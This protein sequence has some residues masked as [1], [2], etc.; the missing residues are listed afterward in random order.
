MLKSFILER[1]MKRAFY[2]I[3]VSLHICAPFA[4]A[5]SLLID[6]QQFLSKH[7]LKPCVA[8]TI[9]WKKDGIDLTTNHSKLDYQLMSRPIP[10]KRNSSLTLPFEVDLKEGGFA[11]RF[12]SHDQKKFLA[13]KYYQ[14][15]GLVKDTLKL[16][17]GTTDE[18]VY[19]IF[20]NN[21]PEPGVSHFIV[22]NYTLT[23][24]PLS[25]EK[26]LTSVSPQSVERTGQGIDVTTNS[27]KLDYQLISRPIP[28]KSNSALELPFEVDL[29]KGGFTVRFL[30]HAQKKF[31]ASKYYQKPGLVKDTL[32]LPFGTTDESVYLIFTNNLPEPGVSR[33]IIKDYTLNR[34]LIEDTLEDVE[35][36]NL[37]ISLCQDIE[38]LPIHAAPINTHG[39]LQGDYKIDGKSFKRQ[40]VSGRSMRCFFNS[41]GL[42]FDTQ[43]A[44]LRKNV[45]NLFVRSIIANEI[46]NAIQ[47]DSSQLPPS[48]KKVIDLAHFQQEMQNISN[49]HQKRS[50]ELK[51]QSVDP[52]EQDPSLLPLELQTIHLEEN[53]AVESLRERAQTEKAF[54]TFL[55]D[56][57]GKGN[58]MVAVPDVQGQEGDNP[59]G[60][61]S[62][63]DAI[64]FLNKIGIKV[65]TQTQIDVIAKL[66]ELGI[67]VDEFT[68]NAAINELKRRKICVDNLTKV[69]AINKLKDL[70]ISVD[71]IIRTAAINKLKEFEISIY[72]PDLHLTHEFIPQGATKVAYIYH[73]GAHFQ[74]LVPASNIPLWSK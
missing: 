6:Q 10:V 45:G 24:S 49:L 36:S 48:L 15:P 29:K 30:S 27:C 65:Y 21:L 35:S 66:E 13:S 7:P 12:L 43:I 32:K 31:L 2:C 34:M 14:K 19:L 47:L 74:A 60:N 39:T 46:V 55:K 8:N 62:S 61:Y 51:K 56:Y 38:P 1:T 20:T 22:K 25:P 17:F 18:S 67:D 37:N 54:L 53:K 42:N 72:S 58:M 63:I 11:V 33:F 28:V 69:D 26:I 23:Q 40:N 4:K 68:K 3:A 41:I 9:E 50:D 64:S 71:K 44:L 16:P 5:T 59:L 57:I 70:K 52:A 73:E